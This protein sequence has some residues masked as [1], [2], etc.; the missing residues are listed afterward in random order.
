LSELDGDPTTTT[1]A[2][3]PPATQ[4]PV[5]EAPPSPADQAPGTPVAPEP[6]AIAPTQPLSP[7]VPAPD[8]NKDITVGSPHEGQNPTDGGVAHK[9]VIQPINDIVRG[10]DM[11]D[12]LKKEAEKQEMQAKV[13][14]AMTPVQ[15]P[16]SDTLVA[17]GGT[18][19]STASPPNP[20]DPNNI[21]L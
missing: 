18:T 1:A 5:V 12:L 16:I 4:I 11:N 21:A 8:I 2:T 6:V 10:P 7:P 17:P 13:A 14:E 20:T 9:K 19:S 15:N 3:P